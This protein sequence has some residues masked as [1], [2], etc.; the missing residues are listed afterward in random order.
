MDLID[1]A[2]NKLASAYCTK[3]GS[4]YSIYPIY[5]DDG[6]TINLVNTN[7]TLDVSGL[8]NTYCVWITEM[9]KGDTVYSVVNGKNISWDGEKWTNLDGTEL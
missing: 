2:N 1:I 3:S 5:N 8:S 7:G 9:R 4:D 6:L